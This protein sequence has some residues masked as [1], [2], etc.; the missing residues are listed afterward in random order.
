MGFGVLGQPDNNTAWLRKT[1][2]KTAGYFADKYL[3]SCSR[4]FVHANWLTI[5]ARV[6]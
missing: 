6:V 2:T 3:I 1:P 5:P 4:G